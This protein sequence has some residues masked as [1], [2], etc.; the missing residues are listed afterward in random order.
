M[1]EISRVTV[2]DLPELARLYQQLG[3]SEGSIPR[4]KQVFERQQDNRTRIVLAARWD[5]RLIGSLLAVTCEMYF[6]PCKS[7]MVIEDVVVDERHRRT[8]VGA[9][10]M[11][12]IETYARTHNCSYIMLITETERV[13]A[14]S[15]YRSLGYKTDEFRAFKKH[16]QHDG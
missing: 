8:G 10:L 14:Q 12:N 1:L 13:S 7:F 15:F 11:E 16:L 2:Q 5:G 4:M 6:G 9:A 3:P